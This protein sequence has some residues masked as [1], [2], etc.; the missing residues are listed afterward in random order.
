[1]VG[2]WWNGEAW[3]LGPSLSSGTSYAPT[4]RWPFL[5]AFITRTCWGV[6]SSS[7]LRLPARWLSVVPALQIYDFSSTWPAEVKQGLARVGRLWWGRG[8][9]DTGQGEGSPGETEGWTA[10]SIL[11]PIKHC[12]CLSRAVIC[13]Q[14]QFILPRGVSTWQYLEINFGLHSQVRVVRLPVASRR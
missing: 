13:N 5:L 6:C 11:F 1:M 9:G 14:D 10:D 4:W 8:L 3:G 12:C 2:C 7:S